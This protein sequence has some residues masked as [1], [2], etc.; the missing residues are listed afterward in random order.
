VTTARLL[1]LP[2]RPRTVRYQ[3]YGSRMFVSFNSYHAPCANLAHRLNLKIR[4][5]KSAAAVD[6]KLS[7]LT[8]VHHYHHNIHWC[9]FI[10]PARSSSFQACIHISTAVFHGMGQQTCYRSY[11]KQIVLLRVITFQSV[12]AVYINILS[13]NDY[14]SI[15]C[16]SEC[17]FN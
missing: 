11:S 4:K 7:T 6:T 1:V 5:L 9:P 2:Q 17:L 12:E 3:K 10:H 8:D 15:L 16:Q 14:T 13:I